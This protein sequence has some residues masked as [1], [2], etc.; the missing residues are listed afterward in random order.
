MVPGMEHC[1]GGDGTDHFDML[2]ALETWVEKKQAPD[3][4]VASRVKQGK[5]DGTRPFMPV[6]AGRGVQG[7]RQ[8]R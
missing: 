7:D 4:I 1:E 6:S 5:V 2:A 8:H 3:R